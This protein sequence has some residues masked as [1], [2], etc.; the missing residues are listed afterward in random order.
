MTNL[1]YVADYLEEADAIAL[2]LQEAAS[3]IKAAIER[4][5]RAGKNEWVEDLRRIDGNIVD[6]QETVKGTWVQS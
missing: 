2:Y 6:M 4:A 5:K 3:Y 1:D